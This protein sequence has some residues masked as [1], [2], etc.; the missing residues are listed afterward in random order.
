MQQ[1]GKGLSFLI[2]EDEA[3]LAMDIEAMV[4]DLGHRVVAEAAE[5]TEVEAL[6]HISAPDVALVDVQLARGSSGLDVSALIQKRWPSTLIVFVTA[7][8]KKLPE[9]FAGAYGVIAKPFSRTGLM[10]ALR[11]I[12]HAQAGYRLP[13]PPPISFTPSVSALANAANGT[14]RPAIV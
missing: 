6:E 9:D 11:Y 3:L 7:N 12:Q 14:E 5:L 10:S 13:Y 1:P 8:P 2:V 4:E